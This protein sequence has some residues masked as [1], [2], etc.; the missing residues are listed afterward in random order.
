[1]AEERGARCPRHSAAT[2]TSLTA[3]TCTVLTGFMGFRPADLG[4]P[5][6]YP[7]A[8]VG[9]NAACPSP[10]VARRQCRPGRQASAMCSIS[11]SDPLIRTATASNR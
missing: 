5:Q 11:N 4:H 2:V 9:V 7:D 6:S 8:G 10:R 3:A 1:M